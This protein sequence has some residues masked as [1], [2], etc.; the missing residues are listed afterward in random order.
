MRLAR[1]TCSSKC[2]IRADWSRVGGLASVHPETPVLGVILRSPASGGAT[3][4][5]DVTGIAEILRGV[6]PESIEGLR[7]TLGS[8]RM[9][10]S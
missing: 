4:N 7:M 8:F 10:T 3:K 2:I 6:Y 1:A 5:L 9:H